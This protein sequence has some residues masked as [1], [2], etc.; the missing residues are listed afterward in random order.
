M[1]TN[2]TEDALI[3]LPRPPPRD[4]VRSLES[5]PDRNPIM[6]GDCMKGKFIALMAALLLCLGIS[7]QTS[8][9]VG[10]AADSGADAGPLSSETPPLSFSDVKPDDYFADAVRWAVENEITNGTSSTTFSPEAVCTRAQV[11]TFLWRAEGCPKPKKG[12]SFPDV[13]ERAYYRDAVAWAME[14]EITRGVSETSFAPN[15]KCTHAQILTFL[16]RGTRSDDSADPPDGDTDP[17]GFAGH[18]ASDALNWAD[19]HGILNGAE[20]DFHPNEYCPRA[21]VALYLFRCYGRT[22]DAEEEA[23][24][25]EGGSILFAAATQEEF[26]AETAKLIQ[27]YR[28]KVSVTAEDGVYATGRLI[29]KAE[30]LPN[31]DAYHPARI[32]QDTEGHFI[33][34][35]TTDMEAAA[36]AGY[37]HT[38]PGITYV[39][40]DSIVTADAGMGA[41]MSLGVVEDDGVE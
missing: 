2:A 27:E 14:Q 24:V 34:Q 36:C 37:L 9:A 3:L 15:Q 16:W 11:V 35:F 31:L 21:D 25:K 23:D 38:V 5:E 32:L 13:G 6:R 33:L 39:E 30:T 17:G 28:D 10:E 19:R 22:S 8:G 26:A 12:T 29:V 7:L 41:G 20:E 1:L 40:P 4:A 18:W